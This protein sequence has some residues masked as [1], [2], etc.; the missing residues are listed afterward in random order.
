MAASTSRVHIGREARRQYIAQYVGAAGLSSWFAHRA[1]FLGC[2]DANARP[3]PTPYVVPADCASVVQAA[4]PATPSLYPTRTAAEVTSGLTNDPY[5]RH[6]LEDVAGVR[7]DANPLRD[8]GVPRCA[9]DA[10]RTGDPVFVR[11]DPSDAGL[12]YV[13][14]IYGDRQ[15][16]LVTVGRN[17]AGLG[18]SG[19]SVGGGGG[20]GMFPPLSKAKA[21]QVGGA[22]AD[23][24]AS[25]E[26]VFARVSG[27][28]LVSWASSAR[29]AP[30]ST[31]CPAIRAPDPTAR[32]SPRRR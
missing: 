23:P 17:E 18:A 25:A 16:L 7:Q 15:V 10:L 8:A 14:V 26:L 24:A 30:S 20:G 11:S 28:Q 2:R 5:F 12:W 1:T 29:A 13:P 31:S 32:S 4:V 6:T 19:G 21:M 22:A 27:A 9:V 3:T